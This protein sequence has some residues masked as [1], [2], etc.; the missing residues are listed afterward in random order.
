[1]HPLYGALPGPYVPVQVTRVH[2][3]SS[4]LQ[5]L[6]VPNDFHS[7][8]TILWNKLGDPVFDDVG[9][10]GFK[11]WAMPLYWSS[12][13]LPFCFLLFSLSLLSLYLLVLLGWGL[14]TDRVLI[15]RSLPTFFN[16]NNNYQ[17][18]S[19]V[20]PNSLHDIP[21]C[22]HVT[23]IS[24]HVIP[25]S[26]RPFSLALTPVENLSLFGIRLRK[27]SRLLFSVEG[28]R[29]SQDPTAEA[30]RVR[31]LANRKKSMHGMNL[32]RV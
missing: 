18:T 30:K 29:G 5:N 14:R 31:C 23:V 11:R 4:S 7:I 9:L 28:K 22:W 26:R 25:I 1:M 16:N 27:R 8:V 12:C 21:I 13:S 2:L 17:L 15:A 3:C 10:A 32:Y 20:I 19:H 24:E 6:A